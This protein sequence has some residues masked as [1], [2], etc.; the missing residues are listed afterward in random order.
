[1]LT[2]F[3]AV[4]RAADVAARSRGP[5]PTDPWE[6]RPPCPE[7]E[8]EE[9][10]FID[11]PITQFYGLGSEMLPEVTRSHVRRHGCQGHG[12]QVPALDDKAFVLVR[13]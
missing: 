3:D 4:A 7:L 6:P 10:L 9:A 13:R 5:V 8:L 2:G 11:D 1:M 12:G